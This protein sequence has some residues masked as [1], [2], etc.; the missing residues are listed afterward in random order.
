MGS[1]S[2]MGELRSLDSLF[3]S[4]GNTPPTIYYIGLSTT[5]ITDA[6]GNITEPSGN[7]YLRFGA[8]NNKTTFTNAVAGSLSNAIVCAFPQASGSWGT[9]SDFFLADHATSAATPNMWGYGALGATK[10][11]SSGDTASFAANAITIT[12]S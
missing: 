12:Q 10:T 5:T 2:D 1:L 11:I 9:V 4:S 7:G 3:G 8:T 6:G